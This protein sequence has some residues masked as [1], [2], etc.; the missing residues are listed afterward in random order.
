MILTNTY[1]F[2]KNVLM[3]FDFRINFLKTLGTIVKYY[4]VA[5]YIFWAKILS[6]FVV[7][8]RDASV[9]NL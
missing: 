3:S 2:Y 8:K 6:A 5:Y 7:K 1:L 9:H 4:E